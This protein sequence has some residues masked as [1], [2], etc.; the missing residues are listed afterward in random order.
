MR[1]A[2]MCA[3]RIIA[4]SRSVALLFARLKTL[5]SVRARLTNEIAARRASV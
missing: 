4:A 3:Q 1:D 5:A 2:Q